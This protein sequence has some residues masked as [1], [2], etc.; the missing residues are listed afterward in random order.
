MKIA[1]CVKH[2]PEGSLKLDPA[3]KRLDRSGDLEHPIGQ[4]RLAVVDVGDDAQ[5]T[6]S[7]ER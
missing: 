1:V 6:E 5:T 3:S 7:G 4:R 2:V